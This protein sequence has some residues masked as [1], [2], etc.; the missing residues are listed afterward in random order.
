MRHAL[1]VALQEFVGAMVIVS[2]DRHM[3][4]TVTDSLL[5][6]ADGKVVPFAGDLDDY[7]QWVKDQNKQTDQTVED[8]SP[9]ET[10]STI[11][12]KQQRQQAAEQRKLLQ[13]LKNKIKKLEQQLEKLSSE[14]DNIEAQLADNNLYDAAN[15]EQLK[16]MLS[17]QS[18]N[19]KV[20]QDVEEQWLVA[21]EEMENLQ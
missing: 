8:A 14:K 16:Q 5:L 15:K 9:S 11:N 12:K 17:Q 20:L 7:R 3:L 18:E 19:I 21:S 4:R 1:S 10:T 6:V 13:P 2:H